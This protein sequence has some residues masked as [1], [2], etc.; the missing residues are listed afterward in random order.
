[1]T[2][3]KNTNTKR[4][5]QLPRVADLRREL[6]ACKQA[7][8]A[9][10]ES[11]KSYH[12]LFNMMAGCAYCRMLFEDGKPNDFI[13]IMV[14]QAFE[15][16][17]G[18][19]DVCGKKATEV[20]PDIHE[21]TPQIFEIYGRVA[22]TGQPEHFEMFLDA[23]Q[24]WASVSV[25]CP[26]PEHFVAVFDPISDNKQAEALA[27]E[28]EAR[29]R[30]VFEH[31]FDGI[32]LTG[33]DGLVFAANPEACR[34][35][36]YTE[37]EICVLGRSVII[38]D[39][40]APYFLA[41]LEERRR[42]GHF[43]G[44]LTF[45]RADGSTFPV[46]I[47][48]SIF[49]GPNGEKRT[50]IIF[51][52][53]TQRQQIEAALRESESRFREVLENSLDASYKRNLLTDAYDYLSPV[54]TR[55]SGYTPDQM[56]AFT[57][58]AVLNLIHPD[59]LAETDR[60]LSE[61]LACAA[62]TA[63]RLEY[64]FKHKDGQYRWFHDRFVIMCDARGHPVARIGSV[65]DITERKQ[66]ED[67][68][69]VSRDY[70]Q[71]VLND[72]N[73]AI[74]VHDAETGQVLDVNQR[75]CEL[76][77]YT[78]EEARQ[79]SIADFSQNQAPYTEMNAMAWLQRAR[80][81]GPQ[82][83]E[84]RAKR[85]DGQLFWVEVGIRFAIFGQDAR[86]VVTVR[87]ISDRK[88][89]DEALYKSERRYRLLANHANDVIWT[90]ALGGQFT[91]VSPSVFQLRG[92]TADEAMQQPL[93]ESV[94]PASFTTMQEELHRAL[95]ESSGNQRYPSRY[96]DVEQPCKDGT[97]VW[98]EVTVRLI[99]DEAERPLEFVGVS[100]DI[101]ERKRLQNELHQRAITDELT[102]VFNRRQFLELA[103]T[104]LKRSI[105]LKRPMTIAMI[106]ID[107][108]KDIND[109]YGHDMGDQ[110]LLAFARICQ[111]NVR[112]IDVFARYGGDEFALLLP[113]TGK[114]QAYTMIERIRLALASDPVNLSGQWVSIT[115]SSGAAVLA[116]V[117]ETLEMLLKHADHALYQAKGAGRNRTVIY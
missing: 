19:K 43:R 16:Q 20:A 24:M 111:R 78:Y 73:A 42:T 36:G 55:I 102:G 50:S 48:S 76:Y 68:L 95:A 44:E 79:A 58:E 47:S 6:A 59:D 72:A 21:T 57:I 30:A 32:M 94:C 65:G 116:S 28:S 109:T 41:A 107:R 64:R 103:R 39:P 54:F 37:P 53:I 27:Q 67:A 15:T 22:T 25:Y 115:S 99:F 71:A 84:W 70:L 89:I 112:E 8:E 110:A 49:P 34:M 98:T 63:H 7:V 26:T 56:Q 113:E 117:D 46:E 9:L 81:V 105:R 14:N 82:T 97:T 38:A 69:R 92:F 4:K 45:R 18:Q 29:Y 86:F 83:F 31:S 93:E 13:Y 11:I 33:P 104:E 80:E 5:V 10:Q 60:V 88:R 62:G 17:M 3:K 91:Y 61:S 87:D 90:M 12:A 51:H 23:S 108:F 77:G 101:T 52:D 74:F 96:F 35:L 1:M 66:M 85:K 100:R 114:E 40:S 106:D 75:M 2:S